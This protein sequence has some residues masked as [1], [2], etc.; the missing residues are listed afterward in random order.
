M[1]FF[2]LSDKIYS[3]KMLFFRLISLVLLLSAG[4]FLGALELEITGGLNN[5]SFH[6]EN[7]ASSGEFKPFP[8]IILNASLMGE[9]TDSLTFSVNFK[10]D[11]IFQNTTD[12]RLTTRTD[13]FGFEFGPFVGINDNFDKPD[14]GILGSLEVTLPGIVFLSF[15][16]SST[17][18]AQFDFTSDNFRETAE[19]RL[20]FWLP[21]TIASLS[22]NTK[23]FTRF[24]DDNN[25]TQSIRDSLKRL[26]LS[27]ELFSKNFPVTL[28]VDGGYQILTRDYGSANTKDE[29]SAFFAGFKINY[30]LARLRITAGAEIPFM[31]TAADPMI[32]SQD[33][34]F[35]AF[36]GIAY[37]FL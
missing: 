29:L 33:F 2:G 13:Y 30:R 5:F 32:A 17:L 28:C 20:G 37:R 12:F 22:V 8:F 10:R 31:I 26:R 35:K 36:A 34:L 1:Q 19:A 6:P 27:V 14:A 18:G 25:S 9:I 16:G 23:S 7:S 21:F 15:S 4:K 24:I 11:N 3:M